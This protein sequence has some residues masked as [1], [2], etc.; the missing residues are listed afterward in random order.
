[1]IGER[2]LNYKIEAR[3]GEGGVGTVYLAT[4]TQ[5]G[6]K[7]AIKVL[8]PT[9]VSNTDI[10]E[11]FRNEATTLSALQ[12]VNIITLYDYLEEEKGLFLILEYAT[13]Q[14]LDDY[15]L[16]V[17]G[18]IPEQKAIYF[19]EQILDGFA[20]A[21]QKGVIHRDIKPSNLI[22]TNDSEVKILDFGIAKILKEGKRNLTKTGTQLGTV[23]YMS[24]EQVQGKFIDHRTDIYSL[25]V[26]LFE[27]LTGKCPYDEQTHTEYQVYEKILKEPLPT[28]SSF[29]PGVSDKMQYIISKATAK[30][31]EDRYQ[32]CEEFKAALRQ[33]TT[34]LKDTFAA[35]IS[36]KSTTTNAPIYQTATAPVQHETIQKPSRSSGSGDI[37]RLK[38]RNNFVLYLIVAVLFITTIWVSY[39][40]F[41]K[42]P[43][44]GSSNLATNTTDGENQEDESRTGN[45]DDEDDILKDSDGEKTPEDLLLDSLKQKKERTQEYLKLLKKDREQELMKGLLI[46]GQVEQGSGAQFL[47]EFVI[48]V[49]V[50]NRRSDA[51][52][53]DLVIGITYFDDAQKELKNREQAL[54]PLD[55]EKSITFRVREEINAAKYATKLKS[56]KV[57]DLEP[58][59]VIDS[60][61]NELKII[62]E[63]MQKLRKKMEEDLF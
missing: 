62:D 49:T 41:F 54:E 13:G 44:A 53:E 40:V 47:G 43:T 60:L 20:Y 57:I 23:L 46:D 19:F 1:M 7:V 15:I 11:R 42:N 51:R 32:S 61:S 29:Y 18:P 27:M 5:L 28:A 52:F 58:T 26:T 17:S 50:A 38:N 14:A 59:Q 35:P 37:E 30:N 55:P 10:R 39:E 24:P 33:S 56:V 31:P 3:L 45:Y 25:G 4:H 6:R 34:A 63:R 48:Q 2:I 21:H 9:L 22:I 12:H 8:N 36:T 16:K